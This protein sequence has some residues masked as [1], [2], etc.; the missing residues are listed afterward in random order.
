MN[1]NDDIPK[2]QNSISMMKIEA[3]FSGPLPPP[4]LLAKYS[5]IIPNGAE[6]IMTM[7]ERQSEHREKLEARVVNGNVAS[8][9][10]GSYFAFILALVAIVGGFYLILKGKDTSGLV[11]IIGSLASLLG[12]FIL[13]KREQKSERVEKS[14][15]LQQRRKR[16]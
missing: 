3:S 9:T 4:S 13:S 8:Q 7:A 14:T 5:D 10:R 1:G 2:K 16:K 12:V 6:R 11:A 15:A